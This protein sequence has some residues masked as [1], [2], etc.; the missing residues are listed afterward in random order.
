MTVASR[1]ELR[2]RRG[3]TNV[4]EVTQRSHRLSYATGRKRYTTVY[5]LLGLKDLSNEN[6]VINGTGDASVKLFLKVE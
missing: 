2:F 6:Y 1:K 3:M 4:K 5:N